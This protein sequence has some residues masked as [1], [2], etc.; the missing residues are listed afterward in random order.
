M[1]RLRCDG[2]RKKIRLRAKRESGLIVSISST[3]PPRNTRSDSR[4]SPRRYSGARCSITWEEK[5]PPS[6]PSG[7]AFR[8]S[9]ASPSNT[10]SPFSRARSSIPPGQVD[11]AA[12]PAPVAQQL[13]K[14]AAAAPEVQDIGPRGK[15][16]NVLFQLAADRVLIAAEAVLEPGVLEDR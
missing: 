16:G 1:Q 13:E 3:P 6:E 2:S 15:M 4:T 8:C 11:A 5:I 7:W 12:G 14:L 10:A 9:R